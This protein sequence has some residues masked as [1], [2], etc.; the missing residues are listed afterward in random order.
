[1]SSPA[2]DTFVLPDA[3]DDAPEQADADE[4]PVVS[5]FLRLMAGPTCRR[6]FW[7][8]LDGEICNCEMADLLDLPQNLISHHL[9]RLR[10][11]G[12]IQSRRDETDHRWVYYS[13]DPAALAQIHQ[14]IGQRLN[15]AHLGTRIPA[16]GPNR[17]AC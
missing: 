12:L 17:A 1:M 5:A 14:E 16:C 6:I 9:R 15:P 11:A 13:V 3:C 7:R 10:Q 8:L 4:S 2:T